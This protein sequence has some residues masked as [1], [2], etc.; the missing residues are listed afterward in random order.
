MVGLAE[1]AVGVHA[2][3]SP[4][5][6][7]TRDMPARPRTTGSSMR[8]IATWAAVISA[9][10]IVIAALMGFGRAQAQVETNTGAV[11]TLTKRADDTDARL[12][13]LETSQAATAAALSAIRGDV[14]EQGATLTRIDDKLDKVLEQHH[15]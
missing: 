6:P 15:H 10:A 9:A 3:T 13:A 4:A 5:T 1:L 14:D 7:P 12:R 2:M 11:G 8:D